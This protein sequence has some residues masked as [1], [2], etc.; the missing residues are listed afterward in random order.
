MHIEKCIAN[1]IL[2]IPTN[3]TMTMKIWTCLIYRNRLRCRRYNGWSH[4]ADRFL[5]ASNLVSFRPT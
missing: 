4:I 5:V 1:H 3:Q 2:K